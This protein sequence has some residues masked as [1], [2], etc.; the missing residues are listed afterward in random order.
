MKVMKK[1]G[2]QRQWWYL[3][4]LLLTTGT[5]VVPAA[6]WMQVER[7]HGGCIN[8]LDRCERLYAS[9]IAGVHKLEMLGS[10][11]AEN[12]SNNVE[13]F[14]APL[15]NKVEYI[16]N[17]IERLRKMS[18]KISGDIAIGSDKSSGCP[19]CIVS[20]VE[21]LCRQIESV[22]SELSDTNSKIHEYEIA[23]KRNRN[24][25]AL[26][27]K[28][29]SIIDSLKKANTTASDFLTLSEV[30]GRQKQAENAL[31]RGDKE[32]ALEISLTIT[33]TL[34]RLAEIDDDSS[35]GQNNLAEQIDRAKALYQKTGNKTAGAV[36]DKAVEYYVRYTKLLSEKKGTEADKEASIALE[37]VKQAIELMEE[38]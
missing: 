34:E 37:L 28:N 29:Q 21:L 23:L 30:A 31:R 7:K 2:P 20:S 17:R 27:E 11:S 3:G 35:S 33:E 6:T 13:E 32:K 4:A 1:K 16:K 18:E 26:M 25:A 38:K 14:I 10:L 15:A 24:V 8:R 19:D 9:F 36:L 22:L 12:G 5:H